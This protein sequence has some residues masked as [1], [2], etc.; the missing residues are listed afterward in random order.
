MVLKLG[1]SFTVNCLYLSV[2]LRSV[3]FYCLV[4]E[5]AD[6]LKGG[7]Y[8]QVMPCFSCSTHLCIVSGASWG[9]I[10]G[11]ACFQPFCS[12]LENTEAQCLV[13]ML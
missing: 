7:T 4:A 9:C 13:V 1:E 5:T 11:K 8:R 3:I 12:V 6:K 10:G 2:R